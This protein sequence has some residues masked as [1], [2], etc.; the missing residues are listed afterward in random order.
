MI[1]H[2]V[3]LQMC[4]DDD[5]ISSENRLS[6]AA[7]STISTAEEIESTNVAMIDNAIYLERQSF[8]E[9]FRQV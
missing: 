3:V 7:R 4:L 5:F 1:W 8:R 6:P 2:F 9:V